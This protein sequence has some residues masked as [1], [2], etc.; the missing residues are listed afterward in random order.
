MTFLKEQGFGRVYLF[1][2]GNHLCSKFG[3]VFFVFGTIM[4]T[5]IVSRGYR[6]GSFSPW[7]T[8]LIV[9]VL[10]SYISTFL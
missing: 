6:T 3:R 8:R 7:F 2:H 4:V 9:A 1:V 5:G 10:V